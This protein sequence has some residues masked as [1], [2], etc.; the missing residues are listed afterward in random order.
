MHTWY[1]KYTW[2][3]RYLKRSSSILSPR[4]SDLSLLQG[5]WMR[6]VYLP[7]CLL[8]ANFNTHMCHGAPKFY[9]KNLGRVWQ[10]RY[11]WEW[12]LSFILCTRGCTNW[13]VKFSEVASMG[14][15]WEWVIFAMSV[16]GAGAYVLYIFAFFCPIFVYFVFDCL[17]SENKCV[18]TFI[19]FLLSYS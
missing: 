4:E 11:D 19:L 14:S 3:Y 17:A 8:V 1:S 13:Y 2:D 5:G 15:A 9:S 12:K 18:L 6:P 16:E 10:Q 7:Y